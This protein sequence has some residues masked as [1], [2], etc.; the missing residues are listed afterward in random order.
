MVN[1]G[2]IVL[3]MKNQEMSKR[4]R[5][6]SNPAVINIALVGLDGVGKSALM[7]RFL[8]RRF[9]GEYDPKLESTHHYN[10]EVGNS[11]LRID[12]RDTAGEIGV[13]L[14]PEREQMFTLADAFILVYSIT[15]QESFTEVKKLYKIIE[16]I[17]T[18]NSNAIFV[19]IGNKKDL[20]HLRKVKT[21]EGEKLAKKYACPF[22]ELS[23]AEDYIE[24]NKVFQEVIRHI[25]H[26]KSKE[27]SG[28]LKKRQNSF[29]SLYKGLEKQ[30]KG[31]KENKDKKQGSLSDMSIG[32][33][34]ALTVS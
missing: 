8:T 33:Y 19:L 30:E 2:Q 26:K 1:S 23:V 12:M 25:L 34:T 6:T 21:E 24:T 7:V 32:T 9:I 11:I 29:S 27:E 5:Q 4:Q 13:P 20:H 22:F 3:R 31:Q 14:S 10:I 16:D 18:N 28:Q 17:R 15:L